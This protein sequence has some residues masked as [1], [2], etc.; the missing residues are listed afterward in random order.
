[1][2]KPK[3]LIYRETSRLEDVVTE[4]MPNALES[5]INYIPKTAEVASREVQEV[6]RGIGKAV[7]GVVMGPVG[8]IDFFGRKILWQDL[9]ALPKA[10]IYGWVQNL[11]SMT[12]DTARHTMQ[13]NW[14]DA[15]KSFFGGALGAITVTPY[16][17]VK[18]GIKGLYNLGR[19]H[20]IQGT[21]TTLTG[22]GDVIGLN[23]KMQPKEHGVIPGVVSIATG[24]A[25]TVLAPLHPI[26]NF[27]TVQGWGG[28]P[29]G[30]ARE[31]NTDPWV[32]AN[33]APGPAATTSAND[34]SPGP[35]RPAPPP[36]TQASANSAPAATPAARPT[37]PPAAGAPPAAAA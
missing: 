21:D 18:N 36:H 9:A 24:A 19:F 25:K 12:V 35:A 6:G 10:A 17:A 28:G 2:F 22:I 4:T 5:V 32:A 3:R 30:S 31:Y 14:K 29:S 20:I 34:H 16:E 33:Q 37:P 11:K 23:W 15:G 7:K 8:I 1:M 27:S 26:S 13:R